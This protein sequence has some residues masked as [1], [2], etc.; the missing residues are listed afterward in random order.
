MPQDSAGFKV[1][2]DFDPVLAEIFYQSY[3]Q[4]TPS[5][6]GTIIGVRTSTKS[7][8]TTQRVGSF[9]DPQPW[10]GQVHYDEA[11]S[12]YQIRWEHDH[13]TMGFKVEQT[14]LEDNQYQGIFDSAANLGQSFNRK[15][16][17]DEASV[18][19]NAFAAGSP[20]YDA[21]AL[22]SASHPLSKTDATTVSNTAGTVALTE[23]NLEAAIVQLE[24]LGDDRGEE[25]AAMAT[26]LVVGRAQRQKALKLTGSVLEAETANNAIN[27]HTGLVPVVHPLITGNKWFVVDAPMALRQIIWWWRI[28]VQF[29]AD[30]DTSSL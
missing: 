27:T 18:F 16:V 13:L 4:I 6:L 29:G 14:L 3:R 1:L 2:T 21:V 23:A 9:G 8:E 10:Q 7:A 24:G 19:N 12:D 30:Q 22:C 25:T 20:G 5:L 26:H 28:P 11:A 15:I 17:K